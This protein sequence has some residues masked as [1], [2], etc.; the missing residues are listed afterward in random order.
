MATLAN[1]NARLS[2]ENGDLQIDLAS[3]AESISILAANTSQTNNS[4]SSNQS[5][6]S[7]T[8]Q[9]DLF[10][11]KQE[12]LIKAV[13]LSNALLT[14]IKKS[15]ISGRM[16]FGNR[17]KEQFANNPI[18][19]GV[20]VTANILGAPRRALGGIINSAKNI[21]TIPGQMLGGGLDKAK[22]A[23]KGALKMPFTAVGN[24]FQSKSVK[25]L[26]L[27]T[28][29]NI[30]IQKDILNELVTLNKTI[31]DYIKAKKLK[32]LDNLED[33]REAK[34]IVNRGLFASALGNNQNNEDDK[35]ENAGKSGEGL[36]RK[37]GGWLLKG[38]GLGVGLGAL[39]KIRKMFKKPTAPKA[40]IGSTP[41]VRPT[42]IPNVPKS[43]STAPKLSP[44]AI[45]PNSSTAPKSAPTASTAPKSAPTAPN[46]STAPK[47]APTAPTA[48][49][50]APTAP[51]APKSAPTAPTAPKSNPPANLNVKPTPKAALNKAIR[52]QLIKEAAEKAAAT[53]AQINAGKTAKASVASA[54]M[55]ASKIAAKQVA[56]AAAKSAA[57]KLPFGFGLIPALAFAVS[58]VMQGDLTGAAMEIAS[59]TAAILPGPGTVASVGIDAAILARDL[60]STDPN[61][62]KNE[63]IKKAKKDSVQTKLNEFDAN[64]A[65]KKTLLIHEASKD[66]AKRADYE[67]AG[68]A[69]KELVKKVTITKPVISSNEIIINVSQ[70]K[71][72][73]NLSNDQT[74]LSQRLQ[75]AQGTFDEVKQ[76]A[77]TTVIMPAVPNNIDNSSTSVSHTTLTASGSSSIDRSDKVVPI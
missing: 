56:K 6:Y 33:Q 55:A 31:A 24:A 10:I 20:A 11:D 15:G 48:P 17:I 47:S 36:F 28:E 7:L 51:T 21:A 16:S 41:K 19:R 53:A 30:D 35:D 57:K 13:T 3:L 5:L 62:E 49:K 1:I 9:F 72:S 37:L 52:Q 46:S 70:Q 2:A 71:I 25:T 26:V 65:K 64:Q 75:E 14:D 38:A 34:K 18:T 54:K 69:A 40:K 50:S 39:N 43:A 4:I 68:L 73:A 58:E 67:K 66:V 76:Q 22:T 63:K 42:S 77:N 61:T 59:G 44:P 27:L 8:S 23:I 45:P 12:E 74:N 60:N 32:N 29:N